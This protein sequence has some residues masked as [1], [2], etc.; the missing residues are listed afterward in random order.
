MALVRTGYAN[1]AAFPVTGAANIIYVDL[2]NGNE[3]IWTTSYIPYVKT[4]IATELG[5]KDSAW[6]TTNASLLLGK[7]QIV[8]LQQTGT[9]KLGDGITALSALLFL[10]G[11]STTPNFQEVTDKGNTT[12]NDVSA[13]SFNTTLSFVGITDNGITVL[14]SNG[15]NPLF[16]VDNVLDEVRYAGVEVA[17]L[18]DIPSFRIS[19]FFQ[20]ATIGLA[21]STS[22]FMCSTP[23]AP[24]TATSILRRISAPITGQLRELEYHSQAGGVASSAQ[25]IS[26]KVNNKTAGTSVTVGNIRYDNS[27]GVYFFTGL[28]F[29]VTQNDSLEIELVVPVLTTNPTS[30]LGAGNL[31]FK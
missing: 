27:V 24:A 18:N 2:S 7:G 30:C 3:W 14:D 1:F 28:T 19:S 17:T 11:S 5:Y 22:Y 12:T 9:Y 10:G 13:N 21:D 4:N 16:E 15:T 31:F 23:V 26:L 29:A 8:F 20:H 25:D 6:F